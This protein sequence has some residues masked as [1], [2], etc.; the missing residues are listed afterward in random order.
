MLFHRLLFV[1]ILYGTG[2]G[3]VVMEKS[4]SSV[5][6]SNP[7]STLHKGNLLLFKTKKSFARTIPNSSSVLIYLNRKCSAIRYVHPVNFSRIDQRKTDLLKVIDT[8]ATLR[9]LIEDSEKHMDFGN[10]C[11]R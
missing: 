1:G 6:F 3:V 4:Y 7:K 11:S 8:N 9:S 2:D 10:I 5:R